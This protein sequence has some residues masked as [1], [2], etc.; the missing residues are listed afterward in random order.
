[1]HEELGPGLLESI[2]EVCLLK[3][4]HSKGIKASRQVPIKVNY[5][6]DALNKEFRL[7]LLIEE[8]VIVELKTVDAIAP[9]HEAQLI[10]YLK[11]FE[12]PKG[13]IFNYH[14]TSLIKSMKSFVSET[15]R[16]L[17]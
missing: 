13:I 16:L 17:T 12:K 15:Y 10:S 11:L 1:M 5:K 7:D 8:T 4:L 6:G 14:S 9:I 3:E 2:Y